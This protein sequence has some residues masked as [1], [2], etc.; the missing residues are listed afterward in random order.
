MTVEEK[1]AL[2]EKLT[3]QANDYREVYNTVSAQMY[4]LQVQKHEEIIENFWS[5]R[6][7]ISFGSAVGREA[8][9]DFFLK[10]SGEKKQKKLEIA[11]KYHGIEITEANLGVGDL[12]SR[13]AANPYIVI[14]EDGQSAKGVWFAP[15]VKAEIGE[16]G[17]LH[18]RY[19]QERIG[20]DLIKEDGQWKIWHYNVYPDFTTPLPDYTF[21]DSR[22]QGRTFDDEGKPNEEGKNVVKGREDGPP[23]GGRPMPYCAKSIPIF[24]PPLPVAYD[25]WTPDGDLPIM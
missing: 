4:Y 14:A 19:M 12:E 20:V 6:D 24:K 15:S 2:A 18:G 13:L 22:Y 7:D 9:C 5:L 11:N 21:D 10:E 17:E 8:V 23:E 25:T 16:D 3:Q 1:L